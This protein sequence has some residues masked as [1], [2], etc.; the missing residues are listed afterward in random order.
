[1]AIDFIP[2][3]SPSN[4]SATLEGQAPLQKMVEQYGGGQAEFGGA[5]IGGFQFKPKKPLEEESARLDIQKK[6]LEI[7]KAQKEVG[8]K[9]IGI[10]TVYANLQ[11]LRSRLDELPYTGELMPGIP[12]IGRFGGKLTGL[13]AEV[14]PGYKP[15]LMTYRKVKEGF[16]GLM[17]RTFGGEKG[18]MTDRDIARFVK[19]LPDYEMT[20]DERNDLWSVS[21]N[22]YKNITNAMEIK[23]KNPDADVKANISPLGQTTIKVNGII[24]S[25][26]NNEKKQNIAIQSQP[27]KKRMVDF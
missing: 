17:A 24:Q 15:K 11:D 2:K 4:L 7:K 19:F 27:G 23:S 20:N 25:V 14:A 3:N 26:E 18:V 8:G 16:S 10:N 9:D 13:A 22:M 5:N 1:M 6:R 12:D 21:D